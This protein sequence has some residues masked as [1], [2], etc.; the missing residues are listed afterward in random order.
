MEKSL[1]N[2]YQSGKNSFLKIPGV[3][4]VGIGNKI[5]GGVDTGNPSV[6]VF[7]YEKLPLAHIPARHRIA[8]TIGAFATDVRV[9]VLSIDRGQ[10]FDPHTPPSVEEELATDLEWID[11]QKI[12]ALNMQQ[13]K[14]QFLPGGIIRRLADDGSVMADAIGVTVDELFV[15]QDTD[16]HL[17]TTVGTD[18]VV[19]RVGAWNSFR[20]VFG[21]DYD[22]ATFFIDVGSGLADCG[23]ASNFIFNNVNGIGHSATNIRATWGSSRLLR[24]SNHSWFS[25]RTLLHEMTHQWLFFVDYKDTATGS[26]KDLLHQD[27]V[28]NAGQKG[29]HWGRWVD[30]N[31]SCMDYDRADWVDNGDGTYNRVKHYEDTEPGYFGFHSVDLY[32]M[33]L[34]PDT[35]VTPVTIVQNPTPA[36]SDAS[37]GPYTPTSTTTVGAA[38]IQWAEGSRSP[39]HQNSQRVFHQAFI[40]ITRNASLTSTFISNSQTWRSQHEAHFRSQTGGRAMVD[41]RLKHINFQ[42]LYCKDNATDSGA[43]LSAGCFWESP[44]VWVRNSD[45]DGTDHERPVR[46]QTNWIYMRVRNKSALA[47]DNVTVNVYLGNFNS[48]TPG[49]EFFYP[50]DW[51]PQGLIGS[52]TVNVPAKVGATEGSVIAKIEW[53]ATLIPPAAGWHPCLLGEILPMEKDLTNLHH[54]WENRKLCQRNLTIIDPEDFDLPSNLQSAIFYYDFIVGHSLRGS[55][56]TNLEIEVLK[57][58]KNVRLFVDTGGR[59]PILPELA[60]VLVSNIS[61]PLPRKKGRLQGFAQKIK[62]ELKNKLPTK[63]ML[64]RLGLVGCMPVIFNDHHLLEIM[65]VERATFPLN[66][67]MQSGSLKIWGVLSTPPSKREKIILRIQET[68]KNKRVLG[69]VT[70]EVRW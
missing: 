41:T 23:N 29:Y 70:L 37:A 54:V 6:V 47:Y 36:V 53:P 67:K 4:G 14:L 27:W 17:V 51:N 45:D 68:V 32:L 43:S 28:W 61:I 12:H 20:N 31:N 30:N 5:K 55:L 16:G 3:V 44:D 13:K 39:N 10:S 34:I 2:A 59:V 19:D 56:P 52:A 21:D 18:V 26:V 65:T 9:P 1:L 15:I 42:D 58:S 69:G 8:P 48:L 66:P 25:T 49:T 11:W 63:T 7:V 64:K 24:W 57:T 35:E 22:F 46:E 60:S 38:N 40:V 62:I 33:G 50:V